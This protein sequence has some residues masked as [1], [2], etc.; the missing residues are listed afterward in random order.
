[1]NIFDR[2]TLLRSTITDRR[3]AGAVAARWSGV[4]AKNPALAEDL[5]RIGGILA[6]QPTEYEN[7]VPKPTPIDP[8]RL[9]YDQGR[10]DLAL[11]LLALMKITPYELSQI[12]EYET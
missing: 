7:G 1:M 2:F 8:V 4:A 5:I 11:Q 12:T 6:I 3:M 10:R 9:A